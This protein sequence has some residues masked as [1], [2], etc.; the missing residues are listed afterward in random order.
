MPKPTTKP[1]G[2]EAAR[3]RAELA[4]HI[5]AIIR[6]PETPPR[7]Y[8][9]LLDF[10]GD[11]AGGLMAELSLTPPYI[12]RALAAGR[13]GYVLC[14]GR[15]GGTCPGPERHKRQAGAARPRPRPAAKGGN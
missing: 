10:V 9:E 6:N 12:A 3:R 14:P 13:C 1:R 11:L 8:R 15:R 4:R 7:L 5:A 2:G